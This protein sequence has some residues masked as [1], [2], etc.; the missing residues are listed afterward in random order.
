MPIFGPFGSHDMLGLLFIYF[1]CCMHYSASSSSKI[2]LQLAL[3]HKHWISHCHWSHFELILQMFGMYFLRILLTN[4]TWK[5]Q[6]RTYNRPH[7][8]ILDI[9]ITLFLMLN[10]LAVEE[11]I[12][13]VWQWLL[14]GHEI[15]TSFKY[16]S[17][18][19]LEGPII[20]TLDIFFLS[21]HNIHKSSYGLFIWASD[22]LI[23]RF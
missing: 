20:H 4:Q 17:L 10:S 21:N 1:E 12:L 11:D 16:G 19:F 9:Q 22:P 2:P 23:D 14:H 6:N 7:W 13:H 5:F 18:S 3:S 15:G 8:I